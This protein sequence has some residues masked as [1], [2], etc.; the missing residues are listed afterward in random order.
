MLGTIFCK[1]IWIYN[2]W[3]YLIG[4]KYWKLMKFSHKDTAVLFLNQS[5]IVSHSFTMSLDVFGNP[6]HVIWNITALILVLVTYFLSYFPSP[7]LDLCKICILNSV[8]CMYHNSAVVNCTF[9]HVYDE[10][11]VNGWL[12]NIHSFV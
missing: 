5:V 12:W 3:E 8:K 9:I 4:N 6:T 10:I 11:L 7:V 1:K 2:K